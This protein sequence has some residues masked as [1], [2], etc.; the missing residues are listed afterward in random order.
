MEP[1]FNANNL[2]VILS[3]SDSREVIKALQY[4]I[5]NIYLANTAEI[6][7][8]V[9]K[10]TQSTDVGVR[11]WAKKVANSIG[12]YETEQA[13]AKTEN[14]PED[15]PIDI[16]IQKLKS[17]A[18]TYISLDVIKKLCESEKP[19]A[20]DFLKTY[21]TECTDVIQISYLTKNI[22]I[23]FPSDE[24]LFL[25][26]PFLKHEDDRI[27][28]NTI[29]GIEAIGSPKGVVV[30]T[31]LLEH[32]SN[33]V[34]TNAALALGKFDADKSFAVILKML[35][36]E[37]GSH[38]R[39]SAC[40]A[41]KTLRD[42]RFLDHLE[43]ALLNQNTFS[44]AL[45]AIAAIGGQPAITLLA[46]CYPQIPTNKQPLI[47]NI[48][49][50]LLQ[51]SDKHSQKNKERGSSSEPN[52]RDSSSLQKLENKLK[53]TFLK[54][55]NAILRILSPKAI[56]VGLIVIA[57]ATLLLFW[58]NE[59]DNNPANVT[60]NA[61]SSNTSAP[62]LPNVRDYFVASRN[63]YLSYTQLASLFDEQFR[64]KLCEIKGFI[65]EIGTDKPD[66]IKFLFGNLDFANDK[67]DEWSDFLILR[68]SDS[69]YYELFKVYP[70]EKFKFTKYV[71]GQEVQFQGYWTYLGGSVAHHMMR[72]AIDV[73]NQNR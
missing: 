45:E 37:S 69:D 51:S 44:A 49:V 60:A 7:D 4:L 55:K 29:E 10:L 59:P 67:K 58:Q 63:E 30:I 57:V 32:P 28:A 17:V 23:Y 2:P 14:T 22:G 70:D 25:L 31:Q 13:K 41:I 20:L 64:G 53:E 47:D 73:T 71:V 48:A 12:K 33:R 16:Q 40:H 3:G 50:K 66:A 68:I 61:I 72:K 43:S 1:D 62:T 18:S 52:D 39:I 54:F 9:K 6:N 65:I 56:A 5:A 36:P 26:M 38:F 35:A 11:F 46:N 42:P 27:V 21:L 24:N 19:E 8:C 34:R 15:L